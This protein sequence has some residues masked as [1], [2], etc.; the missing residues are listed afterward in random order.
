[1]KVPAQTLKDIVVSGGYVSA[2]DFQDAATTAAEQG[3]S[4]A[5]ILIFRGLISEDA[6]GKLVAEKIGFPFA[7]IKPNSISA[8]SLKSLPEKL[9]RGYRVVPLKIEGG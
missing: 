6:L 1:M 4:I 7:L 3:K 9:A 8:D 2:S 5:D